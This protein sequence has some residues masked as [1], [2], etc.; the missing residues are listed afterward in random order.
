VSS[1]F[2]TIDKRLNS[3][4]SR[5]YSPSRSIA[6][7]DINSR[8]TSS[9]SPQAAI[10]FVNSRPYNAGDKS[11]E[12]NATDCSS[13]HLCSNST[14]LYGDYAFIGD[15]II[16]FAIVILL[17]TCPLVILL[18][19]LVIVAIKTKRRLQTRS[20][21]LL[22]SLAGTDLAMGLTSQPTFIAVQISRLAGGSLSAYGTLYDITIYILVRVLCLASLFHLVLISADRFVAMKCSFQYHTIMTKFRITVAVACSWLVAVACSIFNKVS[23]EIRIVPIMTA[24]SLVVIIY[25]HGSVYFVCRRHLIQIKSVQPS[26]EVAAKFLEEKKAWKTTGIVMGGVFMCYIL[27]FLSVLLSII[28]PANKK[29]LHTLLP[30]T[31]YGSFIILNSLLNPV[32]YCWRSKVIRKAILQLLKKSN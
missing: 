30:V 16:V 17:M 19:A 5:G 23:P 26:Q 21:I 25:C 13:E 4:N 32:I 31:L 27:G 8:S 2:V 9:A 28:S 24:I 20:N 11:T 3:V 15:F 22:A 7:P 6:K 29:I 18:N 12:M 14:A 10:I 1:L